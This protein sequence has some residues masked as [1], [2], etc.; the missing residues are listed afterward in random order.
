MHLAGSGGKDKLIRNLARMFMSKSS[1]CLVHIVGQSDTSGN[2]LLPGHVRHGGP[3]LGAHHVCSL[4][5]LLG[6]F[7]KR[8]VVVLAGCPA[9]LSELLMAPLPMATSPYPTHRTWLQAQAIP[10]SSSAL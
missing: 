7:V 4:Q 10:T 3:Q 5:R 1:V 8:R 6:W 9:H 2:I